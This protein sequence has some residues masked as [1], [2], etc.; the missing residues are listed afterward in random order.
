MDTRR[1]KNKSIFLR[2]TNGNAWNGRPAVTDKS[3]LSLL[4]EHPVL[5][6]G[7]KLPVWTTLVQGDFDH[8]ELFSEV[9][10]V[11]SDSDLIEGI[12]GVHRTYNP[13]RAGF[14]THLKLLV[15]AALLTKGD[16]LEMGAGDFSTEV[17]HDIIKMDGECRE[18]ITA[19]SNKE[20]IDKIQD[21]KTT[22][23]NL[24]LINHEEE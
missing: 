15:V 6:H 11:L 20:W 21:K 13:G 1:K 16:I 3:Q 10:E 24:V 19:D 7:V 4:Y 5:P 22:F 18:L 23:H 8:G 9:L 2:S 17:L 12:N 14:G